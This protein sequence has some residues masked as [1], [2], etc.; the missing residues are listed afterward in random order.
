MNSRIFKFHDKAIDG[1]KELLSKT[2]L[3]ANGAKYQLLDT[4]SKIDVLDRPLFLT[5]QRSE[6]VLANITFCR[7]EKHWYIRYFAFD[8]MMQSSGV[9][10]SKNKRGIIKDELNHFFETTL[11]EGF[12]G[13]R[14]ISFYAYIDPQNVKSLWIT[15]QF[16]F[17][18]IG[19]K[20]TQTFSRYFPKQK[21]E[22]KKSDDWSIV[23]EEIK[24]HFRAMNYFFEEIFFTG[25]FTYSVNEDGDFTA[26]A[27]V[28]EANWRIERLPGKFGGVLVKTI[29]FIPILNRLIRPKKHTFH[30]PEAVWVKNND[31]SLLSSFFESILAE[32]KQNL[33]IWWV[34]MKDLLFNSTKTKVN[35]GLVHSVIGASS[36]YVVAKSNDFSF[37][38][39]EK[40]IYSAGMD[41]F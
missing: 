34:D 10:K 8:K 32:N 25:E 6:K 39:K 23:P 21:M 24:N 38:D 20:V 19:E 16:G 7:R 29:P 11:E 30:V 35:W 37:F 22:I 15:E 4:L 17:E 13:S 36:V 33:L 27:K 18:K 5:L 26:F 41:S 28:S 31:D 2:T 40:A 14:P 3:G 1:V 9:A 12:E